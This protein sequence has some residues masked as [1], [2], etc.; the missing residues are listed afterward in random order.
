MSIVRGNTPD[1]HQNWDQTLR[2][3]DESYDNCIDLMPQR[4]N[5]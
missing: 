2:K 3:G 5:I 1:G 4:H